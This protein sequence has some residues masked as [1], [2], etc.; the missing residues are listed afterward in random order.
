MGQNGGQKGDKK[1]AE[2]MPKAAS[3]VNVLGCGKRHALFTGGHFLESKELRE[4]LSHL[5]TRPQKKPRHML[6]LAMLRPIL[7]CTLLALSFAARADED[8][9]PTVY[10]AHYGYTF[11]VTDEKNKRDVE[12]VMLDQP[13]DNKKPLKEVIFNQKLSREIQ[14]EYENRFGYTAAQEVMNSPGRSDEYT[15]YNTQ[16]VG[17]LDYAHYQ[18]QFGE[19]MGRKL[20]E[21]H[22]DNW[23]KNDPAIRPVYQMKD[24]ISNLNM[25]VKKGYKIKWKYN[26]AGPNMEVSVDNPYEIENSVHM[27]MS[28]I[29]SKPVEVIYTVAYPFTTRVKISFVYKQIDGVYQVVATRKINRHVSTSLTASVDTRPEGPTIQQNLVLLGFSYSE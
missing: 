21:Y 6:Y 20:V 13:K 2:T 5:E 25:Q 26:F 17:I 9:K 29:V 16:N 22:F 19:Y 15:Y 8:E 27:D 1:N 7:A 10:G 3:Q 14:K 23:A 4:I 11:D 12:M 18:R 28:G 24:R